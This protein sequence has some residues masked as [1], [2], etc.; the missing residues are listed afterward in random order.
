MRF[1]CG[2]G[3]GGGGCH[4]PLEMKKKCALTVDMV[5][6]GGDYT[7]RIQTKRIGVGRSGRGGF[8]YKKRRQKE[9]IQT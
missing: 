9:N 5:E 6:G 4:Q 2:H 7:H 3:G 8:D 1:D